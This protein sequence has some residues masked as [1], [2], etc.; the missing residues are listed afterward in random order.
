MIF[1]NE[2]GNIINHLNIEK[3]EQEQVSKYITPDCVVLE[4]GARYGTVSCIINS[5]LSNPSNQVSVEPDTLV[6]D[7]LE[8]NMIANNCKFHIIKGA[9]SNTPLSI[10]GKGYATRTLESAENTIP[11][12][13]LEEIE[14]KY[15]LTFNTLV[16]D[17]EG[18]LETF[19]DQNPTFY[20]QLKLIIFE[21][22]FPQNCNYS[23][24]IKNLQLHNFNQFEKGFR[25]VWSKNLTPLQLNK[26]ILNTTKNIINDT[27]II[28]F[29]NKSYLPIF[30]IFYTHFNKLKLNNLLVISIDEYS[31]DYLI[32]K[33]INTILI[34]YTITNISDFFGFRLDIN[35]KI[36]KVSK[37]NILH[38][39]SDCFWYKNILDKIKN[40]DYDIIGSPGNPGDI[41]NKYFKF[42]T[43]MGFVLCC[44]FYYIRYSNK[45]LHF[46]D[47]MKKQLKHISDD[48]LRFN[49]YI[50]NNYRK[51]FNHDNNESLVSKV[52][53]LPNIKISILK[54]TII[55]R[56][57]NEDLYCFHP[58]LYSK[59]IE[60]K[61]ISYNTEK[62]KL[63][64][65]SDLQ[66]LSKHYNS[67]I[68][69]P[70]FS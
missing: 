47:D 25:Q 61:I 53:H 42:I 3:Q 9:I 28:T 49:T 66:N 51:I 15:N 62:S 60:E 43:S 35:N 20:K 58:F 13:S 8:K 30:D 40:L 26:I 63:H 55:S 69:Y 2:N 67:F 19:F 22:D 14:K 1:I 45:T 12:Y 36:F 41:K 56:I 50:L 6:W 4:L 46:F 54:Q 11:T 34:N 10:S 17:C 70:L 68:K 24:I 18:F 21:K 31:Y 59:T 38:T 7:C 48:Q 64:T 32:S 33:N 65:N 37:K 57:N 23:K 52:I 5:K 29:I 27:I 44:G 39:D 16:A